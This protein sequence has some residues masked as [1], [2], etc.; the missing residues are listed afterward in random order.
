MAKNNAPKAEFW[1]K[2]EG[3]EIKITVQSNAYRGNSAI[4]YAGTESFPPDTE[5]GRLRLNTT[6]D[7]TTGMFATPN[8]KFTHVCLVVEGGSSF[9]KEMPEPSAESTHHFVKKSEQ[10]SSTVYRFELLQSV[11]FE[12]ILP[13]V[14]RDS[15][16]V[17]IGR[18]VVIEVTSARATPQVYTVEVPLAV[19]EIA[20]AKPDGTMIANFAFWR[21]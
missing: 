9:N 4:V 15:A 2:I 3:S 19:N 18:G 8:G 21:R 7:I 13:M 10:I 5:I 12:T 1:A 11:R 17:E 6:G 14:V 20:V 16:G